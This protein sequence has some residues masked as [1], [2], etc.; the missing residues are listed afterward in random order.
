MRNYIKFQYKN[1]KEGW[2]EFVYTD[3][4]F[5]LLLS[6]EWIPYEGSVQFEVG[7]LM[8]EKAKLWWPDNPEWH[9]EYIIYPVQEPTIGIV[10]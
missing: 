3:T 6:E 10:D 5:R 2:I 9:I 1:G 7:L 8:F 4:H